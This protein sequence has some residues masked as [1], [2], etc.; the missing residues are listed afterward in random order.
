MAANFFTSKTIRE[1]MMQS[2]PGTRNRIHHRI[3]SLVTITF[4]LAC[5]DG[6]GGSDDMV[7]PNPSGA[8]GMFLELTPEAALLAETGDRIS[9]SAAVRD[10]R[11]QKITA[12]VDYTSL[13]PAVAIVDATGTVTGLTEGI[14]AIVGT[15]GVAK[16][17]AVVAVAAKRLK[18]GSASV[19]L[20]PTNDTIPTIGGTIT[21]TAIAREANGRL[22]SKSRIAWESMTPNI[23]SVDANGTVRGL[24]KGMG[25]VRAKAGAAA[26]TAVVHVAPAGVSQKLA[27]TPAGDTIPNVGEKVNLKASVLDGAGSVIAATITWSS[28]D[29]SIATVNSEGVV[30]GVA[31][32]LARIRATS[33]ALADTARVWVAPSLP[34]A[35]VAV[36]PVT[37]TI[38]VS[39]TTQLSA[40]V[41]DINGS[42]VTSVAVAWSSSNASVATVSSTGLVKGVAAGT[43][44]ITAKAGEAT[45][46]ATVVVRTSTT[47]SSLLTLS[48]EKASVVIGDTMVMQASVTDPKGVL[49]SSATVSW[50]NSNPVKGTLDGN[51]SS[52]TIKGLEKGEFRVIAKSGTAADTVWVRV[53]EPVEGGEG[54][55]SEGDTTVVK[56]EI[57]PKTDT[58]PTNGGTVNLS[59]RV[60]NSAGGSI[61]GLL[62]IWA[63]LDASIA[64]VDNSGLVSALQQGTA[65][66]TASYGTMKDT[67]LIYVQPAGV[68]PIPTTMRVMPDSVT[69]GSAGMTMML[70]AEVRDQTG[71][72]MG[73]IQVSWVSL[74]PTI[75]TVSNGVITAVKAGTG[76]VRASYSNLA[77]TA[78][79]VVQN[80]PPPG[81]GYTVDLQIVR[82]T[83]TSGSTLVSSAIP[84]PPGVMRP[85]DEAN[86]HVLVNGQEQAIY[87]EALAG[88]FPDGSLRSLLV[89]FDYN[90]GSAPVPAKFVISTTR[91]TPARAEVP[92]NLT[93]SNPLPSAVVLPTDP[94]YLMSTRA[95]GPTVGVVEADAF[96]AQWQSRFHAIGDPKWTYHLSTYTS[97]DHNLAI[98]RNFYDRSLAYFAYW[99]R[100][101]N[102][103]AF[104][105]G[106]HYAI[107]YREKYARIYNYKLQPHNIMIEGE[108]LLYRLLGDDEGRRGASLNA[109]Y[110]R[111]SWLPKLQDPTWQY[112][113]NRP[114]ARVIE[115]F[116]TALQVDAPSGN[117]PS[118]LRKALTAFLA[119]QS[120]DGGYRY[121]AQCNMS[122]NFQTGLWNDALI[123]YWEEFE[124]DPRILTAVQRNNDWMWNTQWVASGGGFKYSEGP[125]SLPGAGG[126]TNPA[127]D[128]NL[129]IV[130]A[131]GFVY[132]QTRD[133]KYRQQGDVV[134]NEGIKRAW[135]GGTPAQ[136]DK[137]FNQQYRSAFRYLFYRR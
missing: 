114:M 21:L 81:P 47:S 64:T 99:V 94:N 132:Q 130:N 82:F 46:L 4:I 20:Y 9:L 69:F 38:T 36:Q 133:A 29:G 50:E 60:L 110:L 136:G 63:S 58:I 112:S 84:L 95:V 16:D 7:G 59:G 43:A 32:G 109:V 83:G 17:T 71:S 79:V 1:S 2:S 78:V 122:N 76:R 6:S 128:L 137:Q 57:T 27:I 100:S 18:P 23:V 107:V 41:K 22:V 106:I 3:F 97:I 131:F 85:G 12:K 120:P 15:S 116:I 62:V 72:T 104:K 53:T 124:Q 25:K 28:L 93:L 37:D 33:G 134:F 135:L 117:W 66:I 73:G 74:D 96:N 80:S 55:G 111:D 40:T 48:P 121:P 88:L 127:P 49:M 67:A 31:K 42:A 75:V 123:R 77:D 68:T 113:A 30:V 101:G 102:A 125:C 98:D 24:G 44:Q 92:V 86:V 119:H 13:D 19:A 51:G 26:D 34:P 103:E 118:E 45:G 89:Q 54:G 87:A 35:I 10:A 5:S 115:A 105:R 61:D 39:G 129:L 91:T 56:V 90:L 11:G 8:K 14:V 52:A 65:R 70:L 126:N 108:A